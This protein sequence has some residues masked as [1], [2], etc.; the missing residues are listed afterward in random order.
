H[1]ARRRRAR[2]GPDGAASRHHA[3]LTPRLTLVSGNRGA[4]PLTD[5]KAISLLREHM[6]RRTSVPEHTTT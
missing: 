3:G 1:P 4:R 6:P 5:L 2:A